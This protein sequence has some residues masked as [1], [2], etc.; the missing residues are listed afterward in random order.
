MKFTDLIEENRVILFDGAMG[1]SLQPYLSDGIPPERLNLILP[2]KV[3][4]VH[5]SYIKQGVDVIETNT[6]GANRIKLEKYNLSKHLKEINSR[7]VRIAKEAASSKSKLVGVSIG[8]LGDLIQPWG[9]ITADQA[10]QIFKEQIEVAAE[11]G[12]DLIVIETM[13]YLK[14]AKIAVVAAKEVCDLPVVCQLTFNEQGR[15]LTGTDPQTAVSVLETLDVEVVGANCSVGPREMLPVVEKMSSCTEKPLIFQPNAGRPYLDQGK[16]IFPVSPEEFSQWIRKFVERGTKIVGGCCGTTP[17]HIKAMAKEVKDISPSLKKIVP[18]KGLS[19]RTKLFLW[20]EENPLRTGV[21]LSL[22]QIREGEEKIREMVTQVKKKGHSFLN[23]SLRDNLEE[24]KLGSLINLIQ[25]TGNL[26][27]TLDV[28]SSLVEEGLKEIEGKSLVFVFP[29]ERGSIKMAKKWGAMMG[30]NIY[31]EEKVDLKE[32]LA[33]ILQ[34]CRQTDVKDS[35]VILK[36][37]LPSSGEKSFSFKNIME[38]IQ[39]VRSSTSVGLI[40]ELNRLTQ[41]FLTDYPLKGLLL[42]IIKKFS[43]G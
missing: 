29:G 35:E 16:T 37:T 11:A 15:T 43:E 33:H 9:R 39:K 18:K 40:L 2:E 25:E 23:L 12:A 22:D 27:I 21:T 4:E 32:E 26:P 36:I 41:G 3:K 10:L 7:A 42:G 6:F 5:L 30:F 17:Y 13:M 28:N 1:T 8:P 19:S 14:E 38:E 34:E 31:L 20:G 24:F